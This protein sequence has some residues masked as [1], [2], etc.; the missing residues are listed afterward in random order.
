[1]TELGTDGPG[2]AGLRA[3]GL[4]TGAPG[5]DRL[6]TSGIEAEITRLRDLK[7]LLVALDFDGVLAPI[8]ERPSDA[9]P[10]PEAAAAV[11]RLAERPGTTV[12]LVS[13]RGVADLAAVSGFGPPVLLVGSHG[14]E[15]GPGL[16]E[17][18]DLLT[19]E[20]RALKE[21]LAVALAELVEPGARLEDKPAGIAVHVRGAPPEVATRVLDAV[22]A[23][24]GSW[25][26]IDS[27][28]GKAVIDLAVLHV[29]KGSAVAAL[30]ER[31]AAQA[32]LFLGDDV[33]DEAV[34]ARLR[35]EDV[36]IKVGP[37]ETAASYRLA[38]PAAAA[39]FLAAL[40]A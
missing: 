23:G 17:G 35:P 13:G 1:M 24:P 30:R 38:D 3:D 15:F 40:S 14:G 33:T 12:V 2:T 32:V 6:G 10:L 20:Q 18:G 4:R 5:A 11:R 8:V 19:P 28:E 25:P 37:G 9:R 22:R 21:R 26:G 16:G 31:F 29:N 39:A 7:P 27:T 36:G 34:F